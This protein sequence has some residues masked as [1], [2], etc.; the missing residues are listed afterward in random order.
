[1]GAPLV[2]IV[3]PVYNGAEY[4]A[5]CIESVLRQTH[6]NWEYTILD[7]RSTDASLTIASRYADL[8]RRIRVIENAT[9]LPALANHNAVLRRIS[10][11]STYCKVVFADDWLFPECLARMTAVAEESPRVGVVGAYCL[12]GTRVTCDGLLPTERIVSGREICRRH[13]LAKVYL[14]GSANSVLY[15]SDLVRES[16]EFFNPQSMHADTEACFRI[17]KDNDFGFVH[18]VLTFTRVRAASLTAVSTDIQTNFGGMLGIIARHGPDCLSAEEWRR[19][20][21]AH[22]AEYYG[23]L[24]KA[25]LQRRGK[26]FWDYHRQQFEAV[27]LKIESSRLIRAL[28]GH[29]VGAALRP[30]ETARRLRGW[31]RR[32]AVRPRGDGEALSHAVVGRVTPSGG[33]DA[34]DTPA[35]L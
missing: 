18:Q 26:V 35:L 16:T 2:S 20:L 27:G 11:S 22:V 32:R 15:R 14:F 3:T 17:L 4:L 5:E 33:V 19:C 7:N 34:F 12:E 8:D 10:P 28:V 29:G 24:G 31:N 1:V 21:A 9:F 6:Q 13:L 30:V 25:A 23:F